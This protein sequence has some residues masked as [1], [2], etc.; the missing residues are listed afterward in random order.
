MKFSIVPTLIAVGLAALI[1]FLAYSLCASND[2]A[3][4]IGITTAL[5]IAITL[6]PIMGLRHENSRVQVNIKVLSTIFL[7]TFIIIAAVMCF[8]SVEKL[9]IYYIIVGIIALLYIGVLYSMSRIK[10]V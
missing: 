3:T 4:A 9:N 10:D 1:G 5:S 2:N 7:W 6:I 8:M